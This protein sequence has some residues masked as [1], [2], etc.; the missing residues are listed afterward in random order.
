MHWET[1]SDIFNNQLLPTRKNELKN[2][3]Q[4]SIITLSAMWN[5]LY[6]LYLDFFP[7]IC[8]SKG[9]L[10]VKIVKHA[11]ICILYWFEKVYLPCILQTKKRNVGYMYES[12]DQTKPV[13]DAMGIETV[14]QPLSRC[15]RKPSI[16]TSLT[17][18]GSSRLVLCISVTSLLPRSFA[19]S[20]ATGQLPVSPPS[21]WRGWMKLRRGLKREL[22]REFRRQD[23]Y[24][25][26]P[27]L[28]LKLSLGRSY[29]IS[30]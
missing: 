24:Q 30:S 9:P 8:P 15:W 11:S 20:R 6:L 13:Y 21:S 12:R 22:R 5:K 25:L 2:N 26:S 27:E 10:F 1:C 14:Y 3:L 28:N 7:S 29:E 17:S 4:L 16:S 18:S 23:K 19:A